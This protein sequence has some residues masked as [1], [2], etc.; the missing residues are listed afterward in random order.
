[1]ELIFK[2]FSHSVI[3]S[4]LQCIALELSRE[5]SKAVYIEFDKCRYVRVTSIIWCLFKGFFW[6]NDKLGMLLSLRSLARIKLIYKVLFKTKV[7]FYSDADVIHI[8]NHISV[9]FLDTAVRV[10]CFAPGGVRSKDDLLNEWD[11]R[12]NIQ[13][14][15]SKIRVPRLIK[16]INK[17]NF[18]CYLDE[19][20]VGKAV[21]WDDNNS[22]QVLT[23]LLETM[24]SYYIEN[25]ISWRGFNEIH[26]NA[27]GKIL[28]LIDSKDFPNKDVVFKEII[29]SSVHG[30][31]S[32][33]NVIASAEGIYVIDWE[34]SKHGSVIDDLY[35][36]MKNKPI[37]TKKIETFFI[38]QR[39]QVAKNNLINA[40]TFSEHLALESFVNNT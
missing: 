1:M 17:S 34:L 6:Q 10:K 28:D 37:F 19:I 18:T 33:G 38:E 25:G 29:C 8:R 5:A 32:L 7:I 20:V 4:V 12:N 39:E 23:L 21:N 24:F 22:E 31:L 36:I 3:N 14:K 11:I 26:P 40:A 16:L 35:K 30:D 9:F 15:H 2:H 27:T 13:L